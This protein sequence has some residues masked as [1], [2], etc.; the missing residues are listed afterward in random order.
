MTS[1]PTKAMLAAALGRPHHIPFG[2]RSVYQYTA[3]TAAAFI[4]AARSS[5]EGAGAFNLGGTVAHV[6]DVIAAIE[7]AEPAGRGRITFDDKPLP[8]PAEMDG[9]PLEAAI[10]RLPVTPL[11]VGVRE[12]VGVFQRAVA[13]G[14]LVVE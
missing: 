10:G 13:A 14:R 1:Q 11:E 12:T 2:G 7:A 3:D 4:Q 5:F 6:R 8:F 9:A